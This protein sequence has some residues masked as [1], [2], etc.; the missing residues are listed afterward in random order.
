MSQA[1][2]TR[3][4]LPA[5]YLAW[6]A[7]RAGV[8]PATIA[9]MGSDG[10]AVVDAAVR[11]ARFALA[12]AAHAGLDLSAFADLAEEITAARAKAEGGPSSPPSRPVAEASGDA[13]GV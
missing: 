3:A 12:F 8:F 13:P 7:P 4:P 5:A 1:T 6:H 10:Q 11:M 2:G 9:M